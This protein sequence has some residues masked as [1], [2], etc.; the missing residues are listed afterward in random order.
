MRAR[1]ATPPPTLTDAHHPCHR[2]TH[3][4]FQLD[5]QRTQR[6]SVT[7]LPG[8]PGPP[9]LHDARVVAGDDLGRV[10]DQVGGLQLEQ[11]GGI[12]GGQRQRGARLRLRGRGHG[13]GHHAALGGRG[14][15]VWGRAPPAEVTVEVPP[16]SCPAVP[17]GLAPAGRACLG[18]G[19]D[20]EQL[21]GVVLVQ[22]GG[23]DDVLRKG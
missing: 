11:V 15:D 9:H 23:G 10:E 13:E 3:T 21:V 12:P 18:A 22:V 4:H 7:S 8:M 14:R 19:G 6:R 16:G 20:D 2:R 17:W 1:G 5:M